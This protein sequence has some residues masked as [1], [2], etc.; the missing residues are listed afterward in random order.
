MDKL[1]TTVNTFYGYPISWFEKC[2]Y[3]EADGY[4]KDGMIYIDGCGGSQPIRMK[5]KYRKRV[6]VD[7]R[8]K[9]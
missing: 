2:L 9:K 4:I 1:D 5:D 6:G 3:L 7:W 8:V